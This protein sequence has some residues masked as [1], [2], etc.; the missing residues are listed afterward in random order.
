MFD[1][2]TDE[3]ENQEKELHALKGTQVISGS[4]MR[5][6]KN[7]SGN[8]SFTIPDTNYYATTS[9]RFKMSEGYHYVS[10]SINGARYTNPTIGESGV[11][12]RVSINC[13]ALPQNGDGTVTFRIAAIGEPRSYGA[14]NVTV[15]LVVISDEQGEFL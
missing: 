8:Y 14:E 13:W 9:I 2:L 12:S 3:I 1:N 11:K 5:M 7:V 15:S 10:G 4:S 6:F